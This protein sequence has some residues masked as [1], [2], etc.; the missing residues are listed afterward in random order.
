M[1][2]A[3]ATDVLERERLMSGDFEDV[4]MDGRDNSR[5]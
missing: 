4:L 1:I 5:Y 3:E 2:A